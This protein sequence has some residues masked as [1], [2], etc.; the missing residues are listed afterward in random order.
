[1]NEP[2]PVGR[3]EELR[4]ARARLSVGAS[5]LFSGPAGIGK[6]TLLAALARELAADG[7]VLRCAPAESDRKLPF[8]CLIDL[9]AEVSDDLVDALP[10]P[11]RTALD[12][13][14]LRGEHPTSDQSRLGVRLAVL[15][16]LQ[17]L[18]DAGPV[19]LVVDDVQWVDR[20]SAEVLAFVTRRLAG[21]RLRVLAA[22]RVPDGEQPMH[23]QLCPPDTVELPVPPLTPRE[24]ARLLLRDTGVLLPHGSV[25]QIHQLADG[26]PFYALELGRAALRSGVPDSPGRPLPVP[27]RLRALLLDRL[28]ELSE[29]AQA[30]LLLASAAT[31]PSLT[32]LRAAGHPH[33]TA[34]LVAAEDCYLAH[35]DD[36]GIVRFRHPLIRAAIYAEAPS[37]L[38]VDAHARLAD[39]VGEPV[40][41]ARHLAL[42]K[43][44][45]DESVAETLMSAAASARRRGAPVIAAELAAM[46]A[47][48]TPWDSQ[49]IR[50]ERRLAAAEHACDAGLRVEA[51]AA[52]DSV[53]ADAR[54]PRLR[55]RARLVLLRNA[56][57]ALHGLG[58]LID[59]GLADAD[60]DPGLEA[61]LRLWLA[62]R[63]LLGG[64]TAQAA[65]QAARSAELAVLAGDSAMAVR[66]LIRLA[67]LQSLCGD[68]DARSTLAQAVRLAGGEP[69]VDLWELDRQQAIIE[70]HDDHLDQAELRLL[71][72]LRKVEE[73][74][75]VEDTVAIMVT[76]A[77]VQTRSGQCRR[78]LETAR[79]AMGLFSEA[80]VSCPP[81]LF[82]AAL[83]EANGGN[84]EAATELAE[85][86]ARE[87]DADG[88]QLYLM[89][90]LAVLGQLQLITGDAAAAVET[91]C[92]VGEIGRRMD[93]RD[94]V[95]VRWH[96][97]L[98]EALVATG[99]LED[100]RE[101]IERAAKQAVEHDRMA[102]LA[103]LDR[104]AALL[105]VAS[106]R[107][108]DGVAQLRSVAERQSG[109]DRARTLIS[110]AGVERR[111]RRRAAARSTLV[112]AYDICSALGAAPWAERVRD[113]LDRTGAQVRAEHPAAALTVAEQRVADL[114][115]AGSTNR[116]VAAVLF[117]SV[118]TVEATLS[119]IY[120]K[121]GVRSRTEL[122]RAMDVPMVPASRA[123]K[124]EPLRIQ[125]G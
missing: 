83:A 110:L 54:S 43:P 7:T 30:T 111:C 28:G 35:A 85:R 14:L 75:A 118:K 58:S 69:P 82:A 51:R 80:G 63:A 90:N 105:D 50:A 106:G 2:G 33:A 89:R 10:P 94:P 77:E 22:E 112:E 38:R 96:A 31:R 36:D 123:P 45:E 41:R 8:V 72:L 1:M 87:S 78:A 100:A 84:V 23:R 3:G 81:A 6:S 4:S 76:L 9:L 117:I 59:D 56:G 62:S 121:V 70:L 114:V 17:L 18:F 13:A 19:T 49:Q 66:A 25:V 11:L 65:D 20:P 57:Q 53:L 32:L 73:T 101:L 95:V 42:A 39:V 79:R 115:R 12:A 27:R 26:N 103:N 47:E 93:L 68:T 91:L 29:R 16:V 61:P 44:H 124:P 34:D 116:E 107:P 48:R 97:D 109:L 24:V 60:G 40:E 102:V 125:A 74:A 108:N 120:R 104:A 64:D 86:G 46:A 71:S 122:V 98:A 67:H 119:R 88:D 37:H 15:Q 55:V 5:V 21:E 99:A 52:A 92:R 113:E